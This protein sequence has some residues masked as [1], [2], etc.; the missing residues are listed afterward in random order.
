MNSSR[1]TMPTMKF[2]IFGVSYSFA[3]NETQAPE[4]RKNINIKPT[5][6]KSF[7]VKLSSGLPSL[8]NKKKGARH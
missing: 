7:M 3:Q 1:A 8:G 4:S 2:S 5:K 6:I